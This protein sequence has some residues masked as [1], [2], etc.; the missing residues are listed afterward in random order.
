MWT[1]NLTNPQS[2]ASTLK[3]AR[4]IRFIWNSRIGKIRKGTLRVIRISFAVWE[5]I[6]AETIERI[7]TET[8]IRIRAAKTIE[9]IRTWK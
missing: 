6:K 9:R 3:Y 5:G 4:S 8:V 7:R 1:T 2:T